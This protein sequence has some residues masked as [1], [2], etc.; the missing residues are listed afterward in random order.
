[1]RQFTLAWREHGSHQSHHCALQAAVEHDIGESA[2]AVSGLDLFALRAL[3]C[4]ASR[5]VLWRPRN[6]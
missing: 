6:G 5:M 1:M 2:R 4:V 3:A